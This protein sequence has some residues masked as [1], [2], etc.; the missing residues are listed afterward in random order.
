MSN[1][2]RNLSIVD[3]FKPLFHDMCL[4]NQDDMEL[5]NV[6]EELNKMFD[7]KD[8]SSLSPCDEKT[9]KIPCKNGEKYCPC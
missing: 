6:D 8:F 3:G 5:K 2:Q 1:L 9:G 4:T 7:V